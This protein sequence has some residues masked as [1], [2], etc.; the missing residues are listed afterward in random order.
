M[1]DLLPPGRETHDG[2][3]K[4]AES[5]RSGRLLARLEQHLH[6]EADAEEIAAP[7][8]EFRN[9]PVEAAPFQILH[10]VAEVADAGENAAAELRQPGAGLD[11]LDPGADELER[12][13]HRA[14]VAHIV[15]EKR[16]GHESSLPA[17]DL[18]KR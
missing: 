10:S 5:R 1:R 7:R 14:E 9:R 12:L 4:N 8:Q 18:M 11:H 2:A 13:P 6:A 17:I 16:N 15:I 3:R